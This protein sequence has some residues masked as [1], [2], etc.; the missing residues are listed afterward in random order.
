M[1][2]ADIEGAALEIRRARESRVPCG[3]VTAGFGL[4]TVEDAYAVQAVNARTWSAGG[5]R[6]VGRKIGLTSAAVQAQMGIDQPDFGSLFADMH[7][8]DGA[9]LDS[10]SLIQP[11]AEAE[12]ALVLERD[13]P[14][15]DLSVAA[16]ALRVAYLT[17]AIEVVDSAIADWRIGLLDTIADN[18]SS[19]VYVLGTECV[20]L[21]GTDLRLCGMVMEK[22]G[23]VVS[24]GVGAA[25]L[26]HPL[27]AALW[28]A[29]KM[30]VLGNMLHAGDVILTG[31]LGPMVSVGPN[32][33]ISVEIAG[34]GVAR[35]RFLAGAA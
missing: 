5:R 4:R 11:R 1:A 29:R 19:G 32:D 3:P 20:P 12:I 10:Q 23:I 31:A 16:L 7:Y 6:I 18:A 9:V 13:C 14:E 15:P 33:S 2:V 8:A 21:R 26:G 27:N 25:C 22:N 28:L 24:T 34:C 30:A 35:A 17:A